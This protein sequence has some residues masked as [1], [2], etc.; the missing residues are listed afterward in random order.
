MRPRVI[1]F[2]KTKKATGYFSPGDFIDSQWGCSCSFDTKAYGKKIVFTVK[3]LPW[4]DMGSEDAPLAPA[5]MAA[6]KEKFRGV[7]LKFS[8]RHLTNNRNKR[9][10]E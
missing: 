9:R 10:K 4:Q 6:I 7:E 3:K 1:A 5:L 8:S 2:L